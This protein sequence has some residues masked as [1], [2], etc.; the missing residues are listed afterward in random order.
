MQNLMASPKDVGYWRND[1]TKS[2][3][4]TNEY[5]WYS[6]SFVINK[7]SDINLLMNIRAKYRSNEYFE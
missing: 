3:I 5:M 2:R 1:K 4:Q 7:F 6:Q